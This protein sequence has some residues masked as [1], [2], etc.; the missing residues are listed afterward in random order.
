[1]RTLSPLVICC[2]FL[3]FSCP[4][5]IHAEAPVSMSSGH[6]VMDSQGVT[7]VVAETMNTGGYTYILVDNGQEQ[8]WVA[9]PETT[10]ALGQD[11]V[12]LPGME[13]VQFT[14][15][16]LNRTFDSIIFSPGLAERNTKSAGLKTHS[17]AE[18]LRQEQNQA[19]AIHGNQL[20]GQSRG[21]Q[22]ARVPP[23]NVQVEKAEAENSYTVA[24]CFE[25]AQKLDGSQVVVR[26]KVVK[27]SSGIMGR[28]WIHIQD[29]SGS[30]TNH[31]HDLVVTSQDMP[32][33]EGIITVT[34]ILHANRDF[35]AGYKYTA[36]IEDAS[37]Q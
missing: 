17:F 8:T 22:G 35:G 9:I 30:P 32:K 6:A 1:M 28:N 4:S 15:T 7:G 23:V 21:S 3:A 27:I 26:G 36:I 12:C 2:T 29:G 37:V 13:Q 16:T 10:V 18:A 24:E 20:T 34:G 11:V 19:A 14:S 5:P 33:K 31:S 25:L